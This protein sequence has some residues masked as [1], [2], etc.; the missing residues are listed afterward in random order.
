MTPQRER[1]VFVVLLLLHLLPLVLLPAFPSQDG[2]SHVEA[3]FNWRH[4]TDPDYPLLREYYI[5]NPTPEPNL[6]GHLVLIVLLEVVPPVIAEKVM[7]A[8]LVILLPLGARYAIRAVAPGAAW[9]A[10]L[11]FPFVYAWPMHM[12]FFNFCWGL[13]L[14]FFV[15]GYW[16]RHRSALGLR[17]CIDIAALSLVLWSAHVVPLV[18]ALAVVALWLAFERRGA[19]RTAVAFAPAVLMLAAFFWRK[20]PVPSEAPPFG[21]L[22]WALVRLESLVSFHEAELV[23]STL[24]VVLFAVLTAAALRAARASQERRP[25]DALLFAAAVFTV[26]YF[27][28]PRRLAGGAYVN[29]RLALFP[30]FALLPWLAAREIPERLRRTAHAAGAA[31]AVAALGLHLWT[32]RLI[33]DQVVELLSTA[34]Q[35]ESQRTL[36]PLAFAPQGWGLSKAGPRVK[37]FLHAA[38]Y[39]AAER[40]VVNLANYEGNYVHFPLI[41]RGEVNPFVHLAREQGLEG[42]PPC[43]DIEAYEQATGKTIDYVLLWGM[44]RHMEDEP[45]TARLLEQ[46][47]RGYVAT[48]TSEP[49]RLVRLY[50]RRPDR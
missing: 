50:A 43:A 18:A 5:R 26:L 44:R 48:F 16:I 27:I 4:Y 37:V 6:L 33:R 23:V 29:E 3:A 47:G 32:G 34:P 36:L 14:F 20:Q 24:L 35:L 45:C 1:A 9:L 49:R 2:A 42:D 17:Q 28:A 39:L 11:V 38:S 22:L 31:L 10:V 19:L 30:F 8:V 40:D 46:L 15:V 7:V 12:G 25:A 21:T 41:F 13:P